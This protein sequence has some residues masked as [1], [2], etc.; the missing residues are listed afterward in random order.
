MPAFFADYYQKKPIS[1]FD[2][3]AD[4][5]KEEPPA[6]DE[7]GESRY[8]HL[9]KIHDPKIIQ[10]PQNIPPL[11]AFNRTT[12]YLLLGP[13]AARKTPKSVILRGTSAHGILELEIPI[14]VLETPG[15]MIHQLAAKKAITELEQGR[16]WLPETK[17]ESGKLLKEHFESRFP[18]MVERE[19]VRL[20]VRFQVSGKGARSSQWRRAEKISKRR[21]IGSGWRTRKSA[22]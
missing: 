11:F 1:V 10:A 16:G 2:T 3:S 12:V 14:Q 20:G 19:A 6:Y 5:D 22:R 13:D 7:T 18:G 4:P 21:K 9:P 8:A 15:E 17:D